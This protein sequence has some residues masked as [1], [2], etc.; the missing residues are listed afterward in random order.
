M[1]PALKSGYVHPH[2][3]KVHIFYY[4]VKK[5]VFVSPPTNKKVGI[6]ISLQEKRILYF[7]KEEGVGVLPQ[8]ALLKGFN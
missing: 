4:R 3:E 6:Y 8:E 2:Q 1:W 5:W 7:I